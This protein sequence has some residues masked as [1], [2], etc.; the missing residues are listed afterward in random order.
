MCQA[1]SWPLSWIPH[2]VLPAGEVGLLSS[3]SKTQHWT[4]LCFSTP[5]CSSGFLLAGNGMDMALGTLCPG[6]QPGTPACP[7]LSPG[8]VL[9]DQ[10]VRGCGQR[11]ASKLLGVS[12]VQPRRQDRESE[13]GQEPG[14][15][16]DGRAGRA[17]TGLAG[18]SG[19]GGQG[20][21]YTVGLFLLPFWPTSKSVALA[22]STPPT[23]PAP[24][25]RSRR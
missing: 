21:R 4:E 12:Q 20:Q 2:E 24:C 16:A 1:L 18:C 13:C 15:R 5:L 7:A 11:R 25:S 3:S 19:G 6:A 17:Q 10:G 14:R 23:C 9:P 8:P 22:L